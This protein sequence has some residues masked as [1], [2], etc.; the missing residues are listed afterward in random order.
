MPTDGPNNVSPLLLPGVILG[1]VLL[2]IGGITT[3]SVSTVILALVVTAVL[4]WTIARRNR[5]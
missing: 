1:G 4:T 2:L 5:T 3:G